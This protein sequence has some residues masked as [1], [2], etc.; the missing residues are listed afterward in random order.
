MRP[1]S[2]HAA[3]LVRTLDVTIIAQARVPCRQEA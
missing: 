1:C 2:K 3:A